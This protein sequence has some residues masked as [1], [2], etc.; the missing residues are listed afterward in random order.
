MV[1][2]VNATSRPHYPREIT[3]YPLYRR[4]G[5]PQCRPGRVRKISTPPGFDPR[6]VQPVARHYTDWVIPAHTQSLTEWVKGLFA[7]C[8]VN[9]SPGTEV[10]NEQSYTSAPSYIPL[11]SLSGTTLPFHLMAGEFLSAFLYDY[12]VVSSTVLQKGSVARE[13]KNTSTLSF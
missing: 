6:T 2:V 8:D 12:P 11:R 10:K 13:G 5:G 3:R 9:R 7:W 4:M 1:W